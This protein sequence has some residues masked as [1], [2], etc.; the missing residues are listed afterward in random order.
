VAWSIL[1]YRVGAEELSAALAPA[2][3]ATGS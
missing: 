1:V 2:G 3:A